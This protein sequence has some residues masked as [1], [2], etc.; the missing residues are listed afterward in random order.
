LPRE[1][2]RRRDAHQEAATTWMRNDP[3]FFVLRPS[4]GSGSPAAP[5]VRSARGE[6]RRA[7]KNA[8]DEPRPEITRNRTPVHHGL[9]LRNARAVPSGAAGGYT[10]RRTRPRQP[11]DAR[12]STAP[13]F[14]P[15]AARECKAPAH[16]G[17]H[18]RRDRH[19]AARCSKHVTERA[20]RAADEP[21]QRRT[22]TP[23]RC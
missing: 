19:A 2:A 18:D 5:R 3:K 1:G 10:A 22:R 4:N 17:V 6:R 13:R 7:G 23:T 8:R 16:R 21:P 11:L 15:E 12:A 20:R 14:A 9:Q